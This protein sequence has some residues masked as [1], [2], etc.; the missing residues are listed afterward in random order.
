MDRGEEACSGI[1]LCFGSFK[2]K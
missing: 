1:V 2:A